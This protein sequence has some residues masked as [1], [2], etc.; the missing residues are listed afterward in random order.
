MNTPTLPSRRAARAACLAATA[1]LTLAGCAVIGAGEHEDARLYMPDPRVPADPAWPEV[2]W[3]LSVSNPTAARMIDSLRIAVRPAPNELQVYKSGG[4]AKRPSDML[5][6]ALLRTL[7]DS[8]R[9]PAVARQGSG[10]SADYKLVL[11]LRRFESDYVRAA[12]AGQPASP[13]GTPAATIEVNA[14]LLH[15]QDQQVI[16]TRTFLQARPATGTAVP[17]VV[18]AFEQALGALSHDLAGWV[19]STGQAHERNGHR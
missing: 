16:A 18:E 15:A 1:L 10:V 4:W 11:D 7:E 3:Q 12:G 5:E 2:S 8:G 17:E 19:L 14:K 6:D 9:I 13:L